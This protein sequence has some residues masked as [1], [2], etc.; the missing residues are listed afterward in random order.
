LIDADLSRRL[1][2]QPGVTAAS[3]ILIGRTAIAERDVNIV[4]YDAASPMLA[5]TLSAALRGM[6]SPG[7]A[8]VD[9]RLGRSVGDIIDLGGRSVPVAALV[10]G[11]SFFF[12]APTVFLPLPMVQDLLFAGRHVASAV[13]IRGSSAEIGSLGAGR[14]DVL[15]ND[16]VL[17]DF[18]RVV[19]SST[20][21]IG[22]I[23]VLLWVMAAGIVAAIV[24]VSVLERT[25][26]FATLKAIGST[27]RSLLF[28][29]VLQS[30]AICLVSALAAV[31]VCRAIS[32][33]F[34][35]PVAVPPSAY[36][37]LVLVAM[38]VALLGSLAGVRKITQT[39]P[40][41]AFGGAS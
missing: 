15:T 24:Y 16:D 29:L 22:I 41:L 34:S 32:P 33:T 1:G 13:M 19:K 36:A 8:V 5:S 38:V 4:G 30:G 23:N 40:A 3:P 21:T 17:A 27:N 18:R 12:S 25:R 11:T 31:A 37:Q 10:R 14:I 26:D 2:D 6:A 9:V 20:D 28:G 39:D 7:G 35:F